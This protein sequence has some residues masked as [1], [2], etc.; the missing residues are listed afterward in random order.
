V[1]ETAPA[2]NFCQAASNTTRRHR[3]LAQDNRVWHTYFVVSAGPGEKH[4]RRSSTRHASLF[5]AGQQRTN[6]LIFHQTTVGAILQWT[7]KALDQIDHIDLPGTLT[8]WTEVQAFNHVL[9]LC[10]CVRCS[11]WCPNLFASL[12]KVHYSVSHKHPILSL[13]TTLC[14]LSRQRAFLRLLTSHKSVSSLCVFHFTR[15]LEIRCCLLLALRRVGVLHLPERSP[16]SRAF[17]PNKVASPCCPPQSRAFHPNKVASPCCPPQ[18]RAFAT[19]TRLQVLVALR[20]VGLLPPEQG[21]KSFLTAGVSL[22]PP[23]GSS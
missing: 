9:C 16:Q 13:V 11:C 14:L 5:F 23:M 18:S 1:K 19:R 4:H 15:P 7:A 12:Q 10:V 6:I 21:C 8:P 3:R 20:R 17:H 22:L 2:K